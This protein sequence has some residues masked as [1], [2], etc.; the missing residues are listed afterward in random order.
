MGYHPRIETAEFANFLTTKTRNSELWFINNQELQDTILGYIAKYTTRYNVSLYALA[1]EG[2]HVHAT[3]K[4]CDCNR[5]HFMRDL[6]SS[7][8][9]AI[10]RYAS[11]YSGGSLWKRR[12]SNE[13]LP[14]SQDIEDKFFYTVLQP[15]QDGLVE[16]PSLYP[17]Y[18]CFH[19]A[20]WGL[21]RTFKIMNWSTYYEAKRSRKE[22]RAI[23]FL[24]TQILEYERLPGYGHLSRKE[25]AHLMIQ[26]L[27]ERRQKILAKRHDEGKGFVGV[28]T[29]KRAI[30]GSLP[31]KP[32]ISTWDS[33]RPR[34]L[35]S[36]SKTR[37][38]V[39]DWYFA[40]Y[41]AYKEASFRYRSGELNV[42]FP[43]GTY[44]PHLLPIDKAITAH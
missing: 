14:E 30:P 28:E 35:C 21:K 37:A 20:I 10:P 23:D 19:D 39:L 7:I 3:A 25:Y 9:R 8:A 2:N 15:V 32:K 27:E 40:I 22:V 33:H 16:K 6:N 1:I 13:F 31:K 18:N 42:S 29:L 5:S 17:G 24:E 44:K 36:C 43:P 26:K 12:Y 34:V 11:T 4:F 38:V 41:C